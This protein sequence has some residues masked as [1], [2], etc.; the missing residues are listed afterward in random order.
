MADA[1][2]Q[3]NKAYDL[4][5][6]IGSAKASRAH[7]LGAV[8]ALE[9]TINPEK[10]FYCSALV[11]YAYKYVGIRLSDRAYSQTTPEALARSTKL[12]CVGYLKKRG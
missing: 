7:W 6:A 12:K 4:S 5:G 1:S 2:K 10:E 11:A 8:A 9:N 3:I